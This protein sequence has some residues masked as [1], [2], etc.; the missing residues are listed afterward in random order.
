MD[1]IEFINRI[2][3][4]IEVVRNAWADDLLKLENSDILKSSKK[5][6][7]EKQKLAT[8]YAPLI[9]DLLDLRE[10]AYSNAYQIQE[11]EYAKQFEDPIKEVSEVDENGRPRDVYWKDGA[12]HKYKRNND[13]K[14]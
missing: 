9:T 5:Y 1:Y 11:E 4:H 6:E 8:K 13:D 2:D 10:K 14:N 3:G 12:W 7:K